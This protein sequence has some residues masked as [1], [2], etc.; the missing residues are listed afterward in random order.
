MKALMYEQFQ[1]RPTIQT[2]NDPKL[3]ED[4]VIIEVKATGL[5]RSDW[6]GWMGHDQDIELP[7]VP[8]HE[9]SGLIVEVGKL[10]KKWKPGDRVTVPFVCA[11]GVCPTCHSGNQQVCNDQFQPGFTHWGSFAEFVKIDR[12]DTNLVALPEE[13][14]FDTAASLGCRF[15]T[16]FRAIVDQG[17][18]SAGQWVAVFGCG[19]VGLSAIMIAKAVGAR[20]IGIDISANQLN[21]AKALGADFLINSKETTEVA[22]SILE[23]TKGGV[24]VSI[25]ALGNSRVAYQSVSSL[26]KRGKHIQVGLLLDTEKDT[27]L[28]M[29]LVIAKELEIVGSHGMQAWRYPE[30]IRM[31]LTDKLHPE[32]LIGKTISLEQAVDALPAMNRFE[33]EGIT[34][35]NQF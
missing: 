25:D 31:I 12:A 27:L 20:V 32:K 18:V 24:Q 21:L 19:G 13:I 5:C 22:A 34:L 15:A 11:C 16:S 23:L 33:S 7:H 29:N 6:H 17:K 28:P 10:V 14:S 35:I 26:Q 3:S 9:F 30:M 2:L 8:G 4:G 1:A